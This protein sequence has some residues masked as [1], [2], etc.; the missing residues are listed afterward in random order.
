[1]HEKI[2]KLLDNIKKQ[3]KTYSDLKIILKKISQPSSS[4]WIVK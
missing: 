3:E 2:E 4:K 1:M